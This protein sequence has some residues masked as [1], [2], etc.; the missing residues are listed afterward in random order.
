MSARFVSK[1]ELEGARLFLPASVN[2]L[3]AWL[4]VDDF[5]EN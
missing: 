1:A 5:I 2:G 3:R 4:E